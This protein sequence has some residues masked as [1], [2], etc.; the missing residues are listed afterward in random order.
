VLKKKGIEFQSE[1]C[2]HFLF[3]KS[4]ANSKGFGVKRPRPY[5]FNIIRKGKVKINEELADHLLT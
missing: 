1:E 2:T 5:K 4:F 3:Q